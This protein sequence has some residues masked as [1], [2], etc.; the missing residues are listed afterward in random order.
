MD[1]TAATIKE[2]DLPKVTSIVSTDNVRVVRGSTSVSAPF[3][4]LE[5]I[6]ADAQQAAT[7]AEAAL[8]ALQAA[9]TYENGFYYI[10][11]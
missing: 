6:L 1:Y 7:D 10:N 2:E 3:G 4:D 8:A 9:F 5:A 11:I